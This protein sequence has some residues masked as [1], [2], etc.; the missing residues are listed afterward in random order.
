M[1]PDLGPSLTWK[2]HTKTHAKGHTMKMWKAAKALKE[3]E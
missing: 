3:D 1:N 2:T